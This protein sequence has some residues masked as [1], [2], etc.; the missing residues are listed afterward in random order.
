VAETDVDAGNP[1]GNP[2]TRAKLALHGFLALNVRET[3]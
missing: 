3:V 1:R 2:Y